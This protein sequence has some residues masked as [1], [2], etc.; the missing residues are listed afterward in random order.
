MFPTKTE[1]ISHTEKGNMSQMRKW[2]HVANEE[3]ETP[4]TYRTI[5]YSNEE[6]I[7][8]FIKRI[9]HD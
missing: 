9:K 7:T 6:N 2:K 8:S 5:T 3:I 1:N 4:F